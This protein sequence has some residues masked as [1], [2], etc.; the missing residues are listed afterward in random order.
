MSEYDRQQRR[1]RFEQF[2]QRLV[3]S[4]NALTHVAPDI[5]PMTLDIEQQVQIATV[6]ED[7]HSQTGVDTVHAE[8]GFDGSGQTV[9]IID[10]GIAWNHY[11]L[12]SGYGEH[13][14]VVGGYD[15]AENDSNPYDDG[16]AGF[17]GTHVAGIV[18][19]SDEA[20]K[21]VASGVDL[22]GLRVFNDAG[23]GEIEWVEQA[24]QWVHDHKDSFENPITT[25]N[26]SLGMDWNSD[27]VPN[28]ATLEDEFS[29]LATDGLFVSV[30][31][32]NSF[33]DHNSAG[34]SY[35]AV[36]PFVVPVASHD[37]DGNL[38]DFSQ[39]NSRV[40]AAPGE[41]IR[42]TVPGHL[43]GGNQNDRFL[44]STGTSMAAPYVA[45]A[46]SLLRQANEF[47]GIENIDQDLLYYQF[48]QTA[49]Q[50]YDQAT[51]GYYYRINVAAAIDAVVGDAHAARFSN[52]TNTGAL[53]DGSEITGTIGKLSDIDAFAFTAQRNGTVT[54]TFETTHDLDAFVSVQN[55]NVSFENNQVTFSVTDGREYKFKV[56]S[57]TGI[58]H[59]KIQ[60]DFSE[61]AQVDAVDLGSHAAKHFRNLHV[62]GQQWYQLTAANNGFLTLATV[63][64]RPGTNFEVRVFDAQM[65]EVDSGSSVNGRLRLDL[66]TQQGENY[67]VK[68]LSE[69]AK[70]DFEVTN[71]VSIRSGSL[72]VNGTAGDDTLA[73][74]SGNDLHIEVNGTGYRFNSANFDSVSFAGKSG[75]DTFVAHLGV[76][77]DNVV[78]T[79][80]VA[81]AQTA[82][83][84]IVASGFENINIDGGDGQNRVVMLDSS[85][86]D[87]F[88]NHG[89]QVTLTGNGF[90]NTAT[91]FARVIVKS[92]GGYDI[93]RLNGGIGNDRIVSEAQH[94]VL[95]M[96]GLQIVAQNFD[97][98]F[99]A[100]G[101][102]VDT[103]TIY[104]S[105]GS[106]HVV[107]NQNFAAIL[108]DHH[109]FTANSIERINVHAD[110]NSD[111]LKILDSYGDDHLYQNGAETVMKGHGYFQFARGF[112]HIYVDA[113]GGNDTALLYDTN[114]N[115]TFV[116]DGSVARL[117]SH[118]SSVTV[119][120][121]D[122]VN[123]HA[124]RGG[125]DL[126][127]L[128]GTHGQDIVFA[129]VESTTLTDSNG[130][131]SRAVG[132]E[133]VTVNSRGGEDLA[134]TKGSAAVETLRAGNDYIEFNTVLQELQIR[135]VERI[136][137][138][139]HG[140]VDAIIFSDFDELDLLTGLG[141]KAIAYL[142]DHRI[143]A[144]D[145]AYLE[146]ETAAGASSNYD[147][148]AVDY[149]FMLRGNWQEH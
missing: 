19:S 2:E 48:K 86:N 23:Q 34:L 116:A 74:T 87:D 56:G 130:V 8:Y 14:R 9:A 73:V 77:N 133:S 37:S 32:G 126:A 69:N 92:T 141:D 125:Y 49:D 89:E 99:A 68:V 110:S 113:R 128:Y 11:A 108:S 75:T 83:L 118:A 129:N 107:L 105:N 136:R 91:G 115:D 72:V 93:A 82:G 22:V 61:A 42:S 66:I 63:A 100:G 57:E 101:G 120:G 149:L 65:K 13:A 121:F 76:G 27:T 55:Q 16:P 12:G 124:T 70:I 80:H 33:Q 138:E 53:V 28:W 15:F 95:R 127:N 78:L 111:T 17:H 131:I 97:R 60:V 135:N 122:R 21:G 79:P 24:L 140:G 5:Q 44:G 85:G 104:G 36:S 119:A 90:S 40:L 98:T 38:S 39:R 50:I 123:V 62:N 6:L 1:R 112:Q 30:A 148:D 3:M 35:P 25:V 58:G 54:L 18:G 84:E 145:F 59:Y 29:Q 7:A 132:F 45:G 43:F 143:V 52:A 137:F 106:D 139:G 10:S 46:S 4:A 41:S 47:I 134:L 81:Q 142:N 146:S 64:D 67:Y 51:S 144:E 109:N 31:A 94:D 103:A 114:R 71:L 88:R 96:G 26:L 20:N 102:G 117:S 147:F